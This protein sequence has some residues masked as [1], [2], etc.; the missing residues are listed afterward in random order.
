MVC[1]ACRNAAVYF[2]AGIFCTI[3]M[4]HFTGWPEL[5]ILIYRMAQKYHC[6]CNRTSL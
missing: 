3:F 1:G 6:M 5:V 2:V 4:S